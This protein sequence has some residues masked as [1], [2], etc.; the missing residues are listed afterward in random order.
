MECPDDVT[1]SP[2]L[3]YHNLLPGLISTYHDQ[4]GYMYI[5]DT[6]QFYYK[7]DIDSRPL[8]TYRLESEIRLF[9]SEICITF[10]YEKNN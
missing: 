4:S 8:L 2:H 6:I 1:W 7:R 10:I 3:G 9:I 5:N